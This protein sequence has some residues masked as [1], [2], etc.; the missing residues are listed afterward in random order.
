MSVFPCLFR[1]KI[2]VPRDN[3]VGLSL[4]LFMTFLSTAALLEMTFKHS[5]KGS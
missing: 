4:L 1:R 3:G 2:V 5:C